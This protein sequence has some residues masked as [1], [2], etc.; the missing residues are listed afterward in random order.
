MVINGLNCTSYGDYFCWQRWI[1]Y[2]G[3]KQT[4]F[5]DS[6]EFLITSQVCTNVKQLA[7]ITACA[8]L[9]T[10][11]RAKLGNPVGFWRQLQPKILL[12][13]ESLLTM[14]WIELT[15]VSLVSTSYSLL[16]HVYAQVAQLSQRDRATPSQLK[17][18]QLLH[19]CDRR[20]DGQTDRITTPK[21][22]LAYVARQ[23]PF[24]LLGLGAEYRC[25]RWMWST[26]PPTV[27]SFWHSP[28]N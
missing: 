4:T 16:W 2:A 6:M 12:T 18:C 28:A 11:N 24:L 8:W 3:S 17:S 25:R 10:G 20:T 21:T 13:L 26:L 15:W 5:M 27:R 19:N 1:P 23:K 7:S 22:A 9:L 14:N